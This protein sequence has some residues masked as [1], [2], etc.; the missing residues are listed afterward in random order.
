MKL[1]ELM[2][3]IPSSVI[4][5]VLLEDDVE[6]E[7]TEHLLDEVKEIRATSENHLR[8]VVEKK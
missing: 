5:R 7:G 8:I 4:Y 3:V 2:A 1:I 6:V